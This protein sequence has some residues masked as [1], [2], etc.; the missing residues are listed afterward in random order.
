MQVT[1]TSLAHI[2]M[3]SGFTMSDLAFLAG[4]DESTICRLWDDPNWLDRITGRSLQALLSRSTR[5]R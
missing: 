5:Y 3:D 2:A 4:L 1:P